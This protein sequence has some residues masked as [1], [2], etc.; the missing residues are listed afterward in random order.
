MKKRRLLLSLLGIL[1]FSSTVNAQNWDERPEATYDLYYAQEFNSVVG[2]DDLSFYGQWNSLSTKVFNENDV[3]T[4]ALKFKWIEK[5]A[6]CS[7]KQYAHP[8]VFETEMDYSTGSNRGGMVIRIAAL[9]ENIQEPVS[10]PGFNREGIA[11][12]PT[13]DGSA[14]IV[15]FSGVDDGYGSDMNFARIQIPKPDEVTSL[16]ERATLRI[17]DFGTSIYVFYNDAPYIR[18]DLYGEN[19]DIYTSGN[20]YNKNMQ[21]M[22]SFEGME[23]ESIGHVAIAQRDAALQ[24]YSV[25]LQYNKNKKVF[26]PA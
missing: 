18:I 10:D 21:V 20:V 1:Y 13:T 26:N 22:G 7:K 19:G 23:I 25:A 14:M 17:E 11:F 2:W 16:L 3:S 8:Y 12:Y 5:R 9:S 15:Q 6:I 4:G 24:L